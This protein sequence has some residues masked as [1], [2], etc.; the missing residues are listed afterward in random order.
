MYS[1][2]QKIKSNEDGPLGPGSDLL[3]ALLGTFVL[4]AVSINEGLGVR[5]K[6]KNMIDAVTKE[7]S[8]KYIT[9]KD[10]RFSLFSGHVI[11][12]DTI[13]IWNEAT[14]QHFYFGGNILF[15][16]KS[17]ILKKE[18]QKVVEKLGIAIKNNISFLEEIQIQ[19]HAD[20]ISSDTFNL[21][22]AA[23]RAMSVFWTFK[24]NCG[25]DPHQHLMSVNSFGEYKPVERIKQKDWDIQKFSDSNNTPAKRDK[26]RRIEVILFY[27]TKSNK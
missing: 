12:N 19:G 18:G 23:R 3:A 11:G 10:N 17:D 27:K 15:D 8:A 7:L 25:I 2:L 6:Q 9:D 20:N 16:P 24:N 21:D 22:L 5:P 14:I 1:A 13:K 4:L 26:N